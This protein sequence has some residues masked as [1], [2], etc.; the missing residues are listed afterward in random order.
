MVKLGT[1]R[2][3]FTAPQALPRVV[4]PAAV[5]TELA[6]TRPAL[7]LFSMVT[8]SSSTLVRVSPS[9]SGAE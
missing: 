5:T 9:A 1:P 8:S 6:T 3:T 7:P 4:R 2:S